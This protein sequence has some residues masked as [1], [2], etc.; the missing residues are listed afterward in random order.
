MLTLVLAEQTYRRYSE[1]DL[2]AA[3]DR[4]KNVNPDIRTVIFD[5]GEKDVMTDGQAVCDTDYGTL[6]G[7]ECRQILT[8]V[9]NEEAADNTTSDAITPTTAASLKL[10]NL[11]WAAMSA[12]DIEQ[13][14]PCRTEPPPPPAPGVCN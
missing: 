13:G 9:T 11:L 14:E 1:S 2:Q 7:Q 5:A 8:N 12:N 3:Y 4:A 10:A 6:V